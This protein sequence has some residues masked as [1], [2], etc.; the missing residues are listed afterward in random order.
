[1]SERRTELSTIPELA[2]GAFEYFFETL[3]CRLPPREQN[4]FWT[5]FVKPKMGATQSAHQIRPIEPVSNS[6]TGRRP[7]KKLT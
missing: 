2:E 6:S 5:G 3:I 7:A 4:R 1:M